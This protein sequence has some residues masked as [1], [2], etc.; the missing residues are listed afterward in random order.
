MRVYDI[1]E[2]YVWIQWIRYLLSTRGDMNL[3]S[4]F[5]LDPF[6]SFSLSL[7]IIYLDGAHEDIEWGRGRVVKYYYSKWG[8]NCWGG[9]KEKKYMRRSLKC[10]EHIYHA[11]VH[12]LN[13]TIFPIFTA[14]FRYVPIPTFVDH[15]RS[16]RN[17]G[18]EHTRVV[19]SSKQSKRYHHV[20]RDA[21]KLGSSYQP[22][23]DRAISID[24]DCILWTGAYN[25]SGQRVTWV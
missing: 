9:K 16:C 23:F 15:V 24:M 7:E 12:A 10:A 17:F 11:N 19:A 21:L 8:M 14:L 3:T 20:I 4:A 5:G 13:T 22:Y 2:S 1:K 6:L 18:V 25:N